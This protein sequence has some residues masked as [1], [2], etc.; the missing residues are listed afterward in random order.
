MDG[1]ATLRQEF[2]SLEGPI[3]AIASRGL[4]YGVHVVVTAS[5]WAELRPALK[6]Q[7]ATRIE[8]RLGDPADSEMDRKRARELSGRPPGRGI[9]ASGREMVIALPRWDGKDDGGV[10]C[11]AGANERCAPTVELLPTHISHHRPG[12]VDRR[13]PIRDAASD[14]AR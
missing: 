12:P 11:T 10:G 9:T 6:D 7:I 5:R 2:E 14:R 13:G 3:T 1:W 4:S 8:L